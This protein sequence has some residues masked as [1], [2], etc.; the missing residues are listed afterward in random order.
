MKKGKGAGIRQKP[1]S[2]QTGFQSLPGGG[3]GGLKGRDIARLVRHSWVLRVG[4]QNGSTMPD[5]QPIYD[6]DQILPFNAYRRTQPGYGHIHELAPSISHFYEA[7]K[8]RGTNEDLRQTVLACSTARAARK[9]TKRHAAEWRPDWNGVRGAVL[10]S[11]LAM[12]M[13]QSAEARRLI[14][15]A[16]DRSIEL[17]ASARRVGG[18]PA[19]FLAS[20]ISR[21]FEQGQS[22]TACRLGLLVLQGYEPDDLEAR[23]DALFGANPPYSAAVYVG[24]E[25]SHQAEAWCM[26]RAVPLRYVGEQGQRLRPEH[27]LAIGERINTLLL[28][29]PNTRKAVSAIVSPVKRAKTRILDLTRAR[30]AQPA[31]VAQ[32]TPSG[33]P[34]KPRR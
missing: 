12:Q 19:P 8:L 17:A 7:E 32:I 21:I 3:P 30:A 10:R 31:P 16:Y 6:P 9:L 4:A 18:V 22:R 33:S 23:L 27:H 13:V 20:N 25:A 34:A 28:C 26:R 15:A 5:S 24:E 14:R 2:G 11:G 29:A 1:P